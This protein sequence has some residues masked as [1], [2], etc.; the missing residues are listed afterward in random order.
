M[1]IKVG[2]RIPDVQVHLLGAVLGHLGRVGLEHGPDEALDGARV[3]DLPKALGVDDG[4]GGVAF[5]EEYVSSDEGQ[6]GACSSELRHHVD[7]GVGEEIGLR[8]EF[9]VS[10]DERTVLPSHG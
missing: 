5:T 6:F 3:L 4:V 8:E 9:F 10:H 7:G 2:D 1:A